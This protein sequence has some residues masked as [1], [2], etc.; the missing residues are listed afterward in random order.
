M[1]GVPVCPYTIG[2]YR[3]LLPHPPGYAC[4][5]PVA[6]NS[7][8][9][10]VRSSFFICISHRHE[11]RYLVPPWISHTALEQFLGTAYVVQIP[12][13]G[14]LDV[15]IHRPCTAGTFPGHVLM[16]SSAI[17]Q[18]QLRVAFSFSYLVRNTPYI[19]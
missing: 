1:T 14:S 17:Q 12:V 19:C 16:L 18:F 5:A 6:K 8:A 2:T 11:P 10:P 4:A 13:A 3:P 9:I 15:E 7:A